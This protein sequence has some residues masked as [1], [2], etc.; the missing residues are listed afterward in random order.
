MYIHR[1]IHTKIPKTKQIILHNLIQYFCLQHLLNNVS[2]TTFLS[3]LIN[4]NKLR[5]RIMEMII[6]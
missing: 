2:T 5:A 3:L 1:E 6:D 4:S